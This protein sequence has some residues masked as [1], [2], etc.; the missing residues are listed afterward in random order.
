METGLIPDLKPNISQS[1]FLNLCAQTWAGAECNLLILVS[2]VQ[3]KNQDN[4]Y[5][6]VYGLL[7]YICASYMCIIQIYLCLEKTWYVHFS[8]CSCYLHSEPCILI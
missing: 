8:H 4:I 7:I 1:L 2:S 3:L 6:E 5:L